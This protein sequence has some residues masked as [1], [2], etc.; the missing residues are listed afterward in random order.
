MS[1]S[2]HPSHTHDVRIER[3]TTIRKLMTA[4]PHTIGAE[5]KLSRAHKLMRDENLRHLPVL[6]GGKLVGVLSQRDLYFLET[7]AGVDV[8]IDTVVD[9]MTPD[10]YTVGPEESLRSVAA[11]MAERK[12]GCAVIIERG[13]VLGIFTATDALRHLA[14]ALP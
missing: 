4:S 12:Y 2:T 13:R 5:Q 9:A 14:D 1:T 7:I 10:V 6:R 11:V 3:S 8:E